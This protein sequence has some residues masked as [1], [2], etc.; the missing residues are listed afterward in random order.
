[1][2][3]S[4]GKQLEKMTVEFEFEEIGETEVEKLT[5]KLKCIPIVK[6]VLKRKRP[7]L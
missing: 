6:V 4:V 1:M 3:T 7:K 2:S 5:A